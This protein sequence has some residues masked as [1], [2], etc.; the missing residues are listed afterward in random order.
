MDEH[1]SEIMYSFVCPVYNEAQ[2][3]EHFYER[4]KAVIDQLG[5]SY[6]ILFINDGSTDQSLPVIRE[7]ARR[8][9]A[10]KYIDFSRNFGHQAAVTAGYDFACGRAVICL[11]SDCQH[12][13]ELITQLVENWQSGAEVVYTVRRDTR[14]ISG[15]RRWAGR[16][17]YR[18][19]SKA[20]GM[21]LIDQA[22]F[23]LVD[24]RVVLALRQMREQARFV[25]GLVRW[26]G[27]RQ[28]GVP[29]TAEKRH[30]GASGYSLR[31]LA[32]MGMAGLLNFSLLP[33]R[34]VGWLA[35]AMLLAAVALLAIGGPMCLLSALR[36]PWLLFAALLLSGLNLLALAAVGEYVG[37]IY[38]EAKS[39]PLY[40]VRHAQGFEADEAARTPSAAVPS[41]E[42]PS[43]FSVMT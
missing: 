1:S 9:G 34:A 11:D 17:V 7:L 15:L 26:A 35:A 41:Q 6:E 12:P 5:E 28:M 30:A 8:D 43:R 4:L 23:R 19:I 18:L 29:Y 14:D 42:N 3:L 16:C 27:F 24:R 25:R 20:S 38:E 37:R 39:R 13:P 32:R 21:D 10:V 33:I 2:G 31:Q 22:D 36:F 40:I